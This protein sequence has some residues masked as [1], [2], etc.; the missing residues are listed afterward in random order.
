[1]KTIT[2]TVSNELEKGIYTEM[3]AKQIFNIIIKSKKLK[4]I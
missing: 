3:I 1:M 2:E 4:K